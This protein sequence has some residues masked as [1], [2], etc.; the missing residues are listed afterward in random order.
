M[1]AL[2]TG[3]QTCALPILQ[4]GES[5]PED[6]FDLYRQDSLAAVRILEGPAVNRNPDTLR[7]RFHIQRDTSGAWEIRTDPSGGKNFRF[8]GFVRD[9]H[10]EIGGHLG[11]QARYT[12][13]RSGKFYLDDLR[14]TN[15]TE[16]R[17][18]GQEWVRPCRTR[19]SPYHKKK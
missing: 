1:C 14:V 13:S 10:Y 6:G 17:R 4:I 9:N 15:R 3:V 5:G 18:V 8:Y 7:C 19:W 12:A 11:L 16:E 2:V